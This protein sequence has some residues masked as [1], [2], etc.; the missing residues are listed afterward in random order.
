MRAAYLLTIKAGREQAY[1]DAHKVVWP[2][3]IREASRAGIRNHSCFVHNSWVFVY[4]EADNVDEA[5]A[6][7]MKKE[8]KQRWNRHMEEYLDAE[9]IPLDEVFH[10]E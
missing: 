10:M 6:E 3:L 4:L 1:R 9:A 8:V 7:L 5:L 2:E